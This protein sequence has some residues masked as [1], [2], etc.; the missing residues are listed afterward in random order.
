LRACI[1]DGSPVY[2]PDADPDLCGAVTVLI[3][4]AIMLTRT[5]DGEAAMENRGKVTVRGLL[6]IVT[7]LLRPL[8]WGHRCPEMPGRHFAQA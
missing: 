4:F 5:S 7:A 3:F 1:F 8:S 2:R 6:S